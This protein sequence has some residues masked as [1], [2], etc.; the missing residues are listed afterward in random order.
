MRVG[1]VVA[2]LQVKKIMNG[3]VVIAGMDTTWVLE[4]AGAMEELMVGRSDGP[5]SRADPD[6]AVRHGGHLSAQD[7]S[8][9]TA[10]PRQ[11]RGA[12][13]RDGHSRRDSR[14]S[15]NICRSPS[16]SVPLQPVRV[17]LQTPGPVD[18]VTLLALL[19]GLVQSQNLEFVEDSSF[20]RIA[21][22]TAQEPRPA[23]A[24]TGIQVPC[25]SSSFGSDTPALPT[26][27]LPSIQLFGGQRC[28]FRSERAVCGDV[29]GRIAAERVPQA[30]G[31]RKLLRT[32][33]TC[34]N[35]RSRVGDHRTGR[36]H[37]L[38]THSGL[39]A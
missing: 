29:V 21:P 36:A 10:Y 37:Q 4:V 6:A 12:I 17:T 19:R 15:V 38:I 14:R 26:S 28:I 18:R 7:T 24:S 27:L 33:R 23:R 16:W 34:A 13:R 35:H 11:Y 39:R 8:A 32:N 2:G 20:Y 9:G 5:D 31:G 30:V 25:S 1:D 3:R 22:K